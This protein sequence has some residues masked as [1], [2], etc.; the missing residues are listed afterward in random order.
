MYTKA[1]K[2]ILAGLL[3]MVLT[4]AVGT[5]A[6]AADQSDIIEAIKSTG[7][8]RVGMAESLPMQFKNPVS[9]TWEGYN[10]DM[11]NDLAKL[12]G[13]K[14]QIV[15]ATWATLIPGLMASKYDIVMCDMWA[16]PERAETVVFTDAYNVY[17]WSVMVRKDT[18]YKTWED[19]NKPGIIISVLA[20]TA[21]E[22][23]AKR[24]FPQ[25]TVKALV[26]EN[27]NAPRLEVANG[28]ADAVVTDLFNIKAFIAQNSQA[29]VRILQEDRVLNPTGLAY[30][31]RPGDYHFLNFLNT[32]IHYDKD[33]G[34][35]QDL[36]VKWVKD[37][38]WPGQKS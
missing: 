22:Q 27:V 9:D 10:V 5:A 30:A 11:A 18:P 4:F 7:T 29:N 35:A 31:I 20:G 21:D 8:L 25:A 13:V 15:D 34:K 14:L 3:T 32:W 37:F 6:K 36:R 26:S 24:Y 17:G 28:R 12:L 19:L 1:C 38:K 33:S 16:T 23:T 2:A